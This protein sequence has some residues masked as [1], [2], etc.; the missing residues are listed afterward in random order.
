[1]GGRQTVG[2]SADAPRSPLSG[3]RLLAIVAGAGH[4]CRMRSACNRQECFMVQDDWIELLSKRSLAKIL[5]CV[6]AVLLSSSRYSLAADEVHNDSERE[7]EALV[8][9][10]LGKDVLIGL[11]ED[12]QR[13]SVKSQDWQVLFNL[14]K[15]SG[16]AQELVASKWEDDGFVAVV[17]CKKPDKTIQYFWMTCKCHE[18]N[19]DWKP[20]MIY[21]EMFYETKEEAALLSVKNPAGDSIYVVF[22]TFVRPQ[23][24]PAKLSI[25]AY[26]NNC[27]RGPGWGKFFKSEDL[28][29]TP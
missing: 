6:F 21:M 8:I 29:F 15:D 24:S 9:K 19:A 23:D 28:I 18:E 5:L 22:S 25:Q 10:I 27:P 11:S 1:M 2:S 12:S 7:L 16:L 3:R 20:R 14:P 4:W 26:L 17:K 13:V